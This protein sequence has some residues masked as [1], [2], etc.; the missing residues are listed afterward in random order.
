N[1]TGIRYALQRYDGYAWAPLYPSRWA[2]D[3]PA[4]G[5]VPA[6]FDLN[7]LSHIPPG[8]VT[9]YNQSFNVVSGVKEALHVYPVDPA[10]G[11]RNLTIAHRSIFGLDL[12]TGK[13]SLNPNSYIATGFQLLSA[14]VDFATKVGDAMG[15]R[16]VKMPEPSDGV[17]SGAVSYAYIAGD[18]I[19]SLGVDT[20]IPGRIAG[21]RGT[22]L[23]PLH[24]I[25]NLPRSNQLVN[26]HWASLLEEWRKSGNIR[27]LFANAFGIYLQDSYGENF[28]LIE[29]LRDKGGYNE[30]VKVFL[31][32]QRD[33]L[34]V[35]F[36]LMLTDSEKAAVRLVD[37]TTTVTS[38]S[39]IVAADG[40]ANN[41]WDMKVFVA[42]ARYL[43]TDH[44][45]Q[46]G[47]GCDVL[48]WGTLL[49]SFCVPVILKR[50]NA[51]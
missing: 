49:F 35:S 39:Y 45:E 42:P 25:F 51:K 3:I 33:V 5:D 47:S 20:V 18:V 23:L 14:G 19:A 8:L 43:P 38:N 26:P 44:P 15:V 1:Y 2:F 16:D 17:M 27:A 41:R 21:S 4:A 32:E 30:T 11:F 9:T 10:A 46:D 31:D 48:S 37:D 36:I 29:W 12:G 7:E 50:R 24:I 13:D 6:R 40:S 28:D 22:G 34:T